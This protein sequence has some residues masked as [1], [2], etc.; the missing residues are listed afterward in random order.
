MPIHFDLET[1][2]RYKQGIEKGE[3]LGEMKTLKRNIAKIL[4]KNAFSVI[5][6]AEIFDVSIDFVLEIQNELKK[7]KKN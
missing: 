3:K 5:E 6:I 1:D 7:D 2:L 4:V